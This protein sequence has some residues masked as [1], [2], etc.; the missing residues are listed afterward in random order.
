MYT[1]HQEILA[2]IKFGEIAG[3]RLDKYLANLKF[4]NSHDQDQIE[5]YDVITPSAYA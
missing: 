3:N 1:V 2:A 5:I 4:G